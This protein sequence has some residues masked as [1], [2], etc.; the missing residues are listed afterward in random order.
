MLILKN[1]VNTAHLK[2]IRFYKNLAFIIFLIN[3]TNVKVNNLMLSSQ[4]FN[5]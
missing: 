4:N 5:Q 1:L 2:L 3:C